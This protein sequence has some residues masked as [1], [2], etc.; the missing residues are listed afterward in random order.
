M[1]GNT[2]L[3]A[4]MRWLNESDKSDAPINPPTSLK[5]VFVGTQRVTNVNG[6]LI[7]ILLP[8]PIWMSSLAL[9]PVMSPLRYGTWTSAH[10]V[11]NVREFSNEKH[12]TLT[13]Q[14]V[15]ENMMLWSREKSIDI[16]N[17]S[18]LEPNWIPEDTTSP[19]NL[20]Y[21][22]LIAEACEETIQIK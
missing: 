6:V 16:G 7:G 12:V 3:T 21:T 17:A 22:A 19:E 1:S 18:R 2:S 11:L 10:E 15:G 13:G 14:T 9:M 8:S 4:I 5:A 20:E